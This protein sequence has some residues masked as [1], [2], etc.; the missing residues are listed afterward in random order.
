MLVL[1]MGRKGVN[2]D[3]WLSLGQRCWECLACSAPAVHLQCRVLYSGNEPSP[4]VGPFHK[5]VV[6]CSGFFVFPCAWD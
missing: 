3:M 5:M 4:S 6:H 2:Q 1:R